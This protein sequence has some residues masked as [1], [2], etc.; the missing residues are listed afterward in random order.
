M[1]FVVTRSIIK[2]DVIMSGF[3][4]DAGPIDGILSGVRV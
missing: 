1:L 4:R 2:P 3:S